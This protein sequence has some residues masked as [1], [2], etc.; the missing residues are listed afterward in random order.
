MTPGIL[1][2]EISRPPR[3]N[4]FYVGLGINAAAVL[5]LIV[6][7]PQLRTKVLPEVLMKSQYVTLVAPV[8]QISTMPMPAAKAAAPPQSA[9]VMRPR[10]MPL[11]RARI[12]PPKEAKLET[13]KP[14]PVPE[15]VASLKTPRPVMPATA[16]QIKIN[17]FDSQK[18]NLPGVHESV[19][20]VQTGGFGDPNGL[21]GQSDARRET[22]TTASVGAFDLPAG[23][24]KGNG[25]AGSHGVSGAVRTAGFGSA[26]SQPVLEARNVNV[27]SGE[28]GDVVAQNDIPDR[29]QPAAK[30][31]IQPV[32]IIYKPRPAYTPEALRNR[33]EGEVL[34]DVVF[35]ASG[36]LHINRVV[37]GLGYG[38]DNMALSAAQQIQFRPALRDGQPY[39]YAALVHIRFELAE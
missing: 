18:S 26:S 23:A 37:K 19:R 24:G 20:K 11:P 15:V 30:P 12:Q 35:E 5:L 39:D 14:K 25:T 13:P 9:R 7:D 2:C 28:F 31:R 36:A 29:Q 22:I 34:L 16:R 1:T 6:V 33:V 10:P 21:P 32:Q 38:L 3:W 17:V 8:T 27:V 4:T